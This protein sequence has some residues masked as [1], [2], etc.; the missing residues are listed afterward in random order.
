MVNFEEAG[1]IVRAFSICDS[2]DVGLQYDASQSAS[3][4]AHAR[5]NKHGE[6]IQGTS[7]G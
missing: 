3:A 2:S 5:E 1:F 6:S 7:R 4:K